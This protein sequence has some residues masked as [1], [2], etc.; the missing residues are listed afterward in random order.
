MGKSFCDSLT[1]KIVIVNSQTCF[2]FKFLFGISLFLVLLAACSGST[3][4]ITDVRWRLVSFQ[5]RERGKIGEYLSV[6][7]LASDEDGQDDFES[8]SIINDAEE[9]YW[10]ASADEW[11]VRAIRQQSWLVLEKLLAPGGA[12]PRGR[13][14]VIVRDYA[15]SQAENSFTITADKN[16]DLSFPSLA[17]GENGALVVA[18]SGGE[19]ILMVQSE[20][21]VL[22]GAFILRRGRNPREPI[23]ANEQI[24]AQAKNLY[25]WEQE[26]TGGHSLLAGPWAAADFLFSINTGSAGKE[27]E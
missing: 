2:N 10:Q 23:L 17:A 13:Y 22:L 11:I 12:A 9:L 6:A 16:T 3:P 26:T 20:A 1:P 5:D 14:R 15:G 24:R 7:V 4:G 27:P 25:L 19:S 8:L 18:S 21:G